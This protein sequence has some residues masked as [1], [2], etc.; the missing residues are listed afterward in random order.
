MTALL[1]WIIL[2]LVFSAFFSGSE[3]AFVSANK[4]GIEVMRNKGHKRGQYVARLFEKP[5]VFLGSMLVGNNISLVIFTMF[6]TKLIEPYFIGVFGESNVVSLLLITL[7]ITVLVLI[8]G[9]YLPKTFF[10][11]Y[12]YDMLYRLSGP[13]RL[14]MWVLAIPTWLMTNLSNFLLKT[15][16]NAPVEDADKVL[17]RIDLEHFINDNIA[18]EETIDKAILT[19]A[20]NLNLLK[21]RECMVP[22]TEII[23]VDKDA[24]LDEIIDVFQSSK[25]SRVLITD[26]DIENVVGYV[27]HQYLFDDPA[28]IKKIIK[29]ISF[30]PEAMNVQDLM[31][32]FIKDN[33]NIACVVD[34]FGGTAGLITLEDI[35]EEIFGEIEDE[36]DQEFIIEEQLEEHVYRFSGRI[37]LSYINNKYENINIP[38]GEYH[39][40]SGYIVM[41]T[42]SIPEEGQECTIDNNR[43]FIESVSDKKIETIVM[44]I[45]DGTTEEPPAKEET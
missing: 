35:L 30:V 2:S 11:L 34:E 29:P 32:K 37:E 5:K 41:T 36:H 45:L 18:E 7:I 3:M 15:V 24:G 40:L 6:M 8:F 20:L 16:L 10:R 17:T 33:T 44:T 43:F 31:S 21:V 19:N 9:E 39:T 26:G 14:F 12:S 13:I 23:S 1:I 28:S 25:H 22:R 27:H 42:E 4:L 38:D